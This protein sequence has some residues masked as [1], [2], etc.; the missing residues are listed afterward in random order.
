MESTYLIIT[1]SS[2]ELF[3]DVKGREISRFQGA[4][5]EGRGTF[6]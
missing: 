3:P 6:K 2:P 5:T 1:A 4:G